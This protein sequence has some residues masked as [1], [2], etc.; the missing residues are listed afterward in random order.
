MH[1][2]RRFYLKILKVYLKDEMVDTLR[3]DYEEKRLGAVSDS[4]AWTEKCVCEYRSH[5]VVWAV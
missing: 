1:G 4:C 5:G 2:R 3:Q